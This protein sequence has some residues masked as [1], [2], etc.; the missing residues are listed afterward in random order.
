MKLY[1]V[2]F[3]GNPHNWY[4]WKWQLGNAITHAKQL[5]AQIN[6]DD[7]T[8]CAEEF[9]MR[10]TPY[11]LSL[12]DWDD[13]DDPIRKQAIPSK[14]ELETESWEMDDPL[15]EESSSPVRTV[16]HRYPDRALFTISSTCATYCRH[17]TR[18]RWAGHLPR[19]FSGD[20][21]SQGIEYIKHHSEIRDVVVS[22]GD[23]LMLDDDALVS[24]LRQLSAIEHVEMI[25]VGTRVLVTLPMRITEELA[26]RLGE[27]TNLWVNTHFNHA[28]EIT[29]LSEIACR[30]LQN[31]GIPVN[32][33][34]VLLRG[35]NDN[36][37]A[38][39]NLVHGL[40]KIRVRP[41][42]LYQCDLAR[43]LKHFRTD[44]QTGINI[45][46]NLRG[47]TSGMCIPQF[48]IDSP[49][50]GGKV[51]VNPNYVTSINDDYVEFVNYLGQTY[52]YPRGE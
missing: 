40:M 41:Y 33:Q 49:N 39:R 11:Y 42:Y 17:C 25:R 29:P 23:P 34:S 44:V 31:V 50:G 2:D 21:L 12:I 38:M 18:K 14:E 19:P 20:D 35:V 46:Q 36:L 8:K 16:V 43:G 1:P 24:I 30:R 51:P 52:R 4:S 32:N 3:T 37:E 27:F 26:Q 45:I 10:V 48:V 47:F 9:P 5:P 7:I 15:A 6:T 13:P 22:G 28:N